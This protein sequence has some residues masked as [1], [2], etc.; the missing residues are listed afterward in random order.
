M[1]KLRRRVPSAA[2]LVVAV[3]LAVAA[4][5]VAPGQ[6]AQAVVTDVT[7]EEAAGG[8]QVAVAASG[9]VS[10]QLVALNPVWIVMD[11]RDAQ[12][13][14]SYVTRPLHRGIIRRVRMSQH[15]PDVVRVI[16]E[17]SRPAPYYLRTFPDEHG[18]VIG[19]PGSSDGRPLAAQAQAPVAPVP[20]SPGLIDLK[21][22]NMEIVDVLTALAKLAHVNLVTDA[23]VRGTITV[24]LT[25]VTFEQAL[26]LVLEPNGL[27]YSM[28]GNNL[29]VGVRPVLR[30]YQLTSIAAKD[31]VANILPVTGIR[32]EQ[33]SVDDANNAIFVYAPPGD[34]ARLRDLLPQVDVPSQATSTRVV[35]L[36][37]IDA[38]T[39]LDLLTP[40]LPDAVAKAV[41]V[42]KSSNSVVVT[43]TVAQMKIVDDLLGQVDN[44]LPQVLVEASV[45][46]VPT[47]VTTNLGVAWQQATTFTVTS[48]G[49]NPTG[50]LSIGVTAPAITAILNTLISENKA[51]LLANPRIAVRDGETARM[52][53][54]D[55]IP[56]QVVNAQGVASLV[57]LDAGVKL[58]ITPRVN[59]GGNVTLRM[60]PEVS[61]IASAASVGVPPTISTRE[62][63]S[64]LTVKDGTSIVLAGL[65]QKNET[66]TTVKVPLLGD[67]PVLGWLFKS[68]SSDTRDTEV[69]FVVTP[70]ILA[71]TQ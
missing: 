48:T 13:A 17:L 36:S 39:F 3:F 49:T 35:K 25:G 57:I 22:R 2:R 19:I 44:A 66:R 33:V 11:V 15:A 46:E 54:G 68:E 28:V 50:Q 41:K 21:A 69:V 40:R 27:G 24:Q 5:P 58:E 31:L 4:W 63:D 64:S 60:H 29:I 32:K 70:H 38:T 52:T 61:A 10:P 23:A 9:P 67:I 20:A 8:L 37:Y 65:I 42:D 51:R 56:F 43:A 6:A 14:A 53:I 62:A 45:A 59:S 12:L 16:V 34:Q 26:A 47:E 55:K 1:R 71:K 7:L 30:R 18:V